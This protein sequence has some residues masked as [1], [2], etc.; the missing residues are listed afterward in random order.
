MVQKIVKQGYKSTKIRGDKSSAISLSFRLKEKK[1][2]EKSIAKLRE[3]AQD[4]DRVD[5]EIKRQL[6]TEQIKWW[7]QQAQEDIA[8]L[9]G[10]FRQ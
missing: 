1:A 4:A 8:A 5:D 2:L 3:M 7:I 9:K 6:Y 10:L